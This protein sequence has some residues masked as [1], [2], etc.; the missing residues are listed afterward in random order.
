MNCV[1]GRFIIHG[2]T[3]KVTVNVV[4]HRVNK[5]YLNLLFSRTEIFGLKN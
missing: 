1:V 2:L 3:D 5:Y 4:L